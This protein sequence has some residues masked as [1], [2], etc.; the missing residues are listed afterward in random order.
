MTT[1]HNSRKRN[2]GRILSTVVVKAIIFDLDNTLIDFMTMKKAA[3]TAAANAM[4]E[5]GLKDHPEDLVKRLFSFYLD[6]GIESDDAFEQ[7][8]LQEYKAVDYRVL[9]AAVNAYL[10]EKYLHL[11]PYPG[12]VETLRELKQQGFKLGIVSDGVRLKAWM[13]LNE[14]GL[15][16]YFDVVVTY[17]DT[18]KQKPAKEPFLRVCDELEVIPEECLMVGDWPER[19]VQGGRS[20]GMKTCLATYGQLRPGKADYQIESFANLLDVVDRCNKE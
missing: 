7:Y 20:V 12:V 19:D 13:R 4:I 10:K 9:A 11:K 16:S 8:L 14:A 17:E 3:S 18:G 2:E 15:D 5:A 1:A 6:H